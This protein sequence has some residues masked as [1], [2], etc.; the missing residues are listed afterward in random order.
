MLHR[1]QPHILPGYEPDGS[2]VIQY[3]FP[4]GIQYPHHPNPG[5][6]Y[7]GTLRTAYL[8][9]TPEGREVLRL[10]RKAFDARLVFKVGRSLSSGL[11][12]QIVWNILH[13]TNMH[14]GPE[15]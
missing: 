10:L 7:D 6:P 13:K 15:K 14:G 1:T 2:I 3:A 4:S 8:P 9:D 5:Q 12:N 11:D